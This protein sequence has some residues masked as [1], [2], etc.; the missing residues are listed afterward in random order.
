MG[1]DPSEKTSL[2]DDRQAES[3]ERPYVPALDEILGV[4]LRG[5][6]GGF[7]GTRGPPR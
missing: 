6:D 4:P 3:L 1:I 2:P 7:A 5:L